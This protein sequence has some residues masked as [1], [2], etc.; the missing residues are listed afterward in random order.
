MILV[1]GKTGQ[2]AQELSYFTGVK[3]LGRDSA[4]LTEPA[5]CAAAIERED[6][7]AVINAAAYTSVDLA[8]N[9]ADIAHVVN[10]VAPEEMAKACARARIPFIHISTD[11]VFDGSGDEPWHETDTTSPLGVYG[12]TKRLGEINILNSNPRAVILR[13]SWVFSKHG[14]NF[15]K[16]ML[17]LGTTRDSLSVVADQ[18]G[19]PTPATAIAHACYKIATQLAAEGIYADKVG[20]YH[21]AGSPH[22]TWA[23]FAR[24]IF[25]IAN[26]SVRVED[27]TSSKYPTVAQRP[28]NSRLDCTRILRDYGIQQPGWETA[29]QK[30]MDT[31]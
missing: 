28:L 4:D 21:F 30:M 14:N 19:G 26:I 9:D 5:S 22:T 3:C 2:V 16:T 20:I 31:P 17:R 25:E 6:T 1:F 11:Y 24:T 23:D 18:V 13:T 12:R 10:A 8:E 29:L 15:V 27:V 7:R